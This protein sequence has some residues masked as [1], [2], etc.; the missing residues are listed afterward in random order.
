MTQYKNHQ[1]I[2]KP[3]NGVRCAALMQQLCE[4]S[5][6]AFV[7]FDAS[8][9]IQSINK[10]AETMFTYSAHD[11][12]NQAINLILPTF[13]TYEP[14]NAYLTQMTSGLTAKGNTFPAEIMVTQFYSEDTTYYLAVIRDMTSD[15]ISVDKR[16]SPRQRQVLKLVVQGYSSREIADQLTISIKTVETHR[17][18]IMTKLGVHNVSSLVRLAVEQNII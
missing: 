8:G 9:Q 1:Q 4:S 11:L 6:D 12:L 15:E 2:P 7:I 5:K 14:I 16:L 3:A 10:K 13:D 18:N 17:A